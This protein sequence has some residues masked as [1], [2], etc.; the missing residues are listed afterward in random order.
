M[1]NILDN[2]CL[3]YILITGVI[4]YQFFF[5]IAVFGLLIFNLISKKILKIEDKINF[6]SKILLSY[7][8]GLSTYIAISMILISFKKFEFVFSY[9]F[10]I[11]LDGIYL[12]YLL[13]KY[14]KSNSLKYYL[15]KFI[16]EVKT[17][18]YKL[19]LI[20]LTLFVL[21]FFLFYLQ[22]SLSLQNK[23]LVYRDPFE[24][25]QRTYYLL[26]HN[27]INVKNEIYPPGVII[28]FA[29]HLLMVDDFIIGYYFLKYGAIHF[30][31]LYLF[32]IFYITMK[33][34]NKIYIS[35]ITSILVLNFYFFTYRIIGFLSNEIAIV[36]MGISLI[37]FIEKN[38]KYLYFISFFIALLYF[39]NP[40][41]VSYYFIMIILYF[42]FQISNEFT[43]NQ[44]F[45]TLKVITINLIISL[46]YI[47][48]YFYFLF[49]SERTLS[50]IIRAY[51]DTFSRS[52]VDDLN[53]TQLQD[54]SLIIIR[55]F[56]Q[57]VDYNLFQNIYDFFTKEFSLSNI[58]FS[59]LLVFLFFSILGLISNQKQ[60][61]K[62]FKTRS[63]IIG[64]YLFLIF[65]FFN[66]FMYTYSYNAGNIFYKRVFGIYKDQLLFYFVF[67]MIICLF[68][69]SIGFFLKKFM[70]NQKIIKCI[71]FLYL[72]IIMYSFILILIIL[73][74]PINFLRLNH[75]RSIEIYH[76]PI[77]ILC[78]F[79]IEY[80]ELTI[81]KLK[82]RIIKMSYLTKKRKIIEFINPEKFFI[83]FFIS[84][85]INIQ[86][87][88]LNNSEDFVFYTYEDSTIDAYL[89]ARENFSKKSI[90]L[91]PD[92]RMEDINNL[93]YDMELIENPFNDLTT[94]DEFKTYVLVNEIEYLILK[95]SEKHREYYIVISST[96]YYELL[97]ENED[98]DIYSIQT[99]SFVPINSSI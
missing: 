12:F 64:A 19:I 88:L 74:N 70:H 63:L 80:I 51:R 42:F 24:Y 39:L 16:I 83:F 45:K 87:R 20:I 69:G 90:I 7:G 38:Q 33:L 75:N 59:V 62:I 3:Y 37:I 94:Y 60:G 72:F 71:N 98:Y 26:D 52:E 79:G 43:V 14:L 57:T 49:S 22:F 11:I 27:E 84:L 1:V 65:S 25:F 29:G 96:H 81:K 28:F 34:F 58:Y 30:L 86:F 54:K 48:T 2:S 76:L 91:I 5:I 46:L 56:L 47:L 66:I 10:F 82:Q 50:D 41:T 35:F 85:I 18:K 67:G 53:L 68:F 4:F 77:I 32:V 78:G 8:I 73:F 61:K 99:Y 40:V 23:S 9:L 44:F 92:F 97:Y 36:F 55:L 95:N 93:L 31:N 6:I 21:S 89:F 13:A 15:R 17:K